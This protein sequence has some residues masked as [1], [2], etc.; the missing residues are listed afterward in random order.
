MAAAPY[1]LPVLAFLF[2]PLLLIA[3]GDLAKTGQADAFF[4]G[5]MAGFCCNAIAMNWTVDLL[6]TFAGFPLIAALPVSALLFLW[7]ALPFGVATAAAYW[8]HDRGLPLWI[9]LPIALAFAFACVPTL[10][11]W[12]PAATLVPWVNY[13]QIA[14]LGGEFVLDLFLFFAGCGVLHAIT[15]RSFRAALIATAC[16]LIPMLYGAARIDHVKELRSTAGRFRV[17]VLQP[18]ISIEDKNNHRTSKARLDTLRSM[19]V[20]VQAQG[21]DII[22]WPETAYPYT[23]DRNLNRDATDYRAI[24]K[25]GVVGPIVVGAITNAK[26]CERYNSALLL[27]SDGSFTSRSDKSHLLPFGETVPFW[28]HLP[29]LQKRFKCPGLIAA[30]SIRPL[31]IGE[32]KIGILNCYEDILPHFARR[33]MLGDPDFLL[34]MTN[35]T[36]FGDSTKPLL[37]HMV[38]TLR[39]VENRRDLLRAVNTGVSGHTL[40]TGEQ[41]LKTNTWEQ[42]S[43]IANVA[44]LQESTVWNIRLSRWWGLR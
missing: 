11:H 43:F 29:P 36:W 9:G 14:D 39:A 4:I 16:V 18:N 7:Q 19:T 44:M 38:A 42:T 5:L 40:A 30:E 6:Q 28:H 12:T 22:V 15:N 17:G 13:I 24:L 32:T 21:V 37:H 3:V 27:Q 23:I 25:N 34:N 33:V 20:I 35:D 8:L 26:E 2:A 10:F 41:A 31:L 1:D